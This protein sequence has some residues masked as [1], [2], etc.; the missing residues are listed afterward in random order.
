METNSPDQRVAQ[1]QL[2]HAKFINPGKII[3]ACCAPQYDWEN[4]TTPTSAG[5][6]GDGGDQGRG[7]A[8]WDENRPRLYTSLDFKNIKYLF[9]YTK[10]VGNG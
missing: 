1:T 4:M 10:V 6:S 2:L 9:N 8:L 5:G 7:R 3:R